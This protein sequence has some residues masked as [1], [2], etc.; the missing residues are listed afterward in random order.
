SLMQSY[1]V[2]AVRERE[3][4]AHIAKLCS[5]QPHVRDAP[6]FLAICADL[7]RIER[8][9][10]RHG[11]V[12]QASSLEIF[13]EATIDAA[14]LGQ[15]VQL[16]A[17]SEGLGACMIGAARNYPVELA[18]LLELPPHVFVAFGMTLGIA[19]DDPLPRSRLPLGSVLHRERYG[20]ARIDADLDAA[21]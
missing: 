17:E 6:V 1:A 10:A 5:D 14:I 12:L 21:D 3:K 13:V 16:A 15:N 18:A 19:A 9:C 4:L 20:Q 2:V 11:G 7:H 8:A